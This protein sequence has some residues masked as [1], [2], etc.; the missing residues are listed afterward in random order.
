MA[1]ISA[2]L[3][4]SAVFAQSQRPL[5]IDVVNEVLHHADIEAMFLA[6]SMLADMSGDP[7]SINRLRKLKYVCT[8]G[9][10][11]EIHCDRLFRAHLRNRSY[12][13]GSS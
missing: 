1:M 4:V 13:R 7:N 5:S 11:Y 3:I 2:L 10:N 9:G 8:G 6:P 12:I